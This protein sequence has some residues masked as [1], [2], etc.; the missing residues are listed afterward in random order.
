MVSN[1]ND[2]G[3][4]GA[5]K[6]RIPT[7][8]A[9]ASVA[10][11]VSACSG[12]KQAVTSSPVAAGTRTDGDISEWD[13]LTRIEGEEFSLAVSNDDE[14]LYLVLHTFDRAAT[15]QILALGLTVWFDP[16]GGSDRVF[17]VQYPVGLMNSDAASS[18]NPRQ[19]EQD[20]SQLETLVGGMRDEIIL[21]GDG[22][23]GGRWAT[24]DVLAI[25]AD[26]E[27]EDDQLTYELRVP[28]KKTS[29]NEYAIGAAPGTIIGVGLEVP[30]PDMA[31]MREHF[32]SGRPSGAGAAGGMP[33]G[34][35]RPSGGGRPQ[36]PDRIQVW[37]QVPLVGG[38]TAEP[39]ASGSGGS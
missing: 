38:E 4:D 15:G 3:L 30:E 1:I 20:P 6:F 26:F 37:I 2:P 32:G 21:R 19:V 27:L 5:V 12:T 33:G 11:L 18:V 36:A 39:A 9:V 13:G 25:E 10:L 23:D 16:Q 22:G 31:E 24:Q 29:W 14:S 28:L 8:L 34:G 7:C 35:G 17:G